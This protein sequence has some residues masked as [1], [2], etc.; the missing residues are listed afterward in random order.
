MIKYFANFS[1]RRV[2]KIEYFDFEHDI[3]GRFVVK[4][5]VTGYRG[6]WYDEK[7]LTDSEDEAKELVRTFI[8]KEIKDIDKLR[9]NLENKRNELVNILFN[10]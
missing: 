1:E 5:P 2:D 3:E 4:D 8:K 9:D 7:Y 6:A 10:V